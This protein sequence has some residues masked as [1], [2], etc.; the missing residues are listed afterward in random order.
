MEETKPIEN[1]E[2]TGQTIPIQSKPTN[3]F[4]IGIIVLLFAALTSASTYFYL[5]WQKTA[6]ITPPPQIKTEPTPTINSTSNWKTYTDT[7]NNLSFKYP[8]S[9]NIDQKKSTV[10]F[11]LKSDKKVFSIIYFP[12]DVPLPSGYPQN[13]RM[14]TVIKSPI[15]IAGVQTTEN[16]ITWSKDVPVTGGQSAITIYISHNGYTLQIQLIDLTQKD[17][18]HQILSTFKFTGQKQAKVC[19]NTKTYRSLEEALK[20]PDKVCYLDLSK[21]NL[22]KLSPDVLKLKNLNTLW[23]NFNKLTTIP[24]ELSVLEN[25]ESIDLT[26]NPLDEKNGPSSEEIEKLFPNTKI[27][28]LRPMNLP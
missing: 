15:E 16:L 10:T 3:R 8:P 7:V 21:K 19:T 25:L 27:L 5:S 14:E 2:Q 6:K 12:F 24:V 17:I 23:L 4:L 28:F 1:I 13:D 9:W 11:H 26:G 18:F 20:E 22:T